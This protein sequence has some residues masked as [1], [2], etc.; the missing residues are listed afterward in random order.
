MVIAGP[1]AVAHPALDSLGARQAFDERPLGTHQEAVM[2]RTAWLATLALLLT[3]SPTFA[4]FGG[5]GGMG[6]GMG[7]G[8]AGGFG[9]VGTR[10]GIQV[11]LEGGRHL[12]GHIDIGTV[13]VFGDLGQYLIT[14]EKMKMIR[15][16]KPMN[17]PKGDDD[18]QPV[19]PVNPAVVRGVMNAN[20]V[21]GMPIVR[22]KVILTS[23]QEIIGN[24]QNFGNVR[25]DLEFGSL[26]PTT[27]KLRTITFTEPERKTEVTGHD[28]AR[29][30]DGPPRPAG[31]DRASASAVPQYYRHANALVIR[32]PR[33]D[34]I[35]L[36]NVESKQTQEFSGPKDGLLDIRP[37]YSP[38]L[39]ALAIKGPK[40]TRIAVAD[41]TSGWHVQDLR[42]PAEGLVS[43]TVAQGVAVYRV[44]RYAYAYGTEADRWDV[45]ELPEGLQAGP[46][47]GQSSI[48]IEGLGHI[49]T[50]TSKTGQWEH[51]D[52][53]K[54]AEAAGAEK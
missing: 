5:M 32:S 3:P 33:G 24:I 6:G 31:S 45:A 28:A 9:S 26:I 21:M 15:F 39:M 29:P 8:M 37:Y 14:P 38:D 1:S 16:L 42:E 43:P 50:F 27:D 34:R 35:T 48:T 36:Y 17:E 13:T 52:V 47:A 22:A 7:G 51:I 11:E 30:D 49:F 44:G 25:L 54:I 20:M 19:A 10:R 53:R 4:Q 41:N 40:I 18:T 12:S 2:N 46:V 23:G